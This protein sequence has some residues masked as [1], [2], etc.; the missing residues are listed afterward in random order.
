[1]SF[2]IIDGFLFGHEGLDMLGLKLIDTFLD[3]ARDDFDYR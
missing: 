3:I 2:K 1:M